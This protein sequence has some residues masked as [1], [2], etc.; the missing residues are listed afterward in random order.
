MVSS[1]VT[2]GLVTYTGYYVRSPSTTPAK[3]SVKLTL[4]LDPLHTSRTAHW[5]SGDWLSRHSQHFHTDAVVGNIHGSC[6][7]GNRDGRE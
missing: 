6:R 1:L 4:S 5:R 3:S 7:V 2:S